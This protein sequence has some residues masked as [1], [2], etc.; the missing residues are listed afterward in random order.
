MYFAESDE[1]G[2]QPRRRI[3]YLPLLSDEA[4]GHWNNEAEPMQIWVDA[5][6]DG[7]PAQR[8]VV[9]P[10][11]AAI[12]D[13]LRRV[14]F[15]VRHEGPLTLRGFA[16]FG[17]CTSGDGTCLWRRVDFVVEIPGNTE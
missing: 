1:K 16:L 3:G 13:E 11:P 10:P 2:L 6:G 15:E 12:S 4:K 17:V 9:D 7:V 5:A 8:F 14:D